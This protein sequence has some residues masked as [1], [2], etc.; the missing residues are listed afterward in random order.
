MGIH[1]L[2]V[3]HVMLLSVLTLL[4]LANAALYRGIR[5]IH[6]FTLYNICALLGALSVSLRGGLPDF[7]SIVVGNLF[8]I[9][10][11]A[12]LFFSLTE[13]FGRQR[14]Q[15]YLH[16]LFIAI[17]V[18]TMVLYGSFEPDTRLRLM[19]YSFV[20]GCQ[21]AQIALLILRKEDGSLRRIGGPMAAVVGA[22][23]LTNLIRLIGVSYQGA[24]NDY[25]Q[26]GPFLAW[27]VPINTCL[28]CGAM[29][30]YVW[31]TSALLRRDLQ[32]QASTD[33]LTGLLNRRAIQLGAERE[34]EGCM[35]RHC[36]IS[37]VF[38]DLD[39]FKPINDTYGHK[40]GDATLIAVAACL[41][42][43]M[44]STDLL[45]RIGGDE[46]AALL[47]NTSLRDATDIAERLRIAIAELVVPYAAAPI[48]LTGSFGISQADEHV[49]W[50]LLA[51]R[52]DQALYVA[53][54]AG[55][56]TVSNDSTMPAPG[57][58]RGTLH[59]AQSLSA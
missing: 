36:P 58:P 8:V 14:R 7:V 21:Q 24:P 49:T 57:D 33:P 17:G 9:S 37:A 54:R 39:A 11:Y 46:F 38:L 12:A 31:M 32:I 1:I 56:N 27:I 6:W 42:R 40:L 51:S 22:L 47:P 29:V 4:T 16:A 45:A 41:Q 52:C 19:A 55:G 43:G 59:I 23:A 53:K 26:A 30:S 50:D 2:H 18:V 34:I 20:L 35:Q 15:L 3:Q 10:A 28:Q 5:G 25:L 44:R 48:R 13:L